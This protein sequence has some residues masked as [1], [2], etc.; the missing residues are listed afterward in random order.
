MPN[1]PPTQSMW[2]FPGHF[3]GVV[4]LAQSPSN[5]SHTAWR[6]AT[7]CSTVC[8]TCCMLSFVA[9]LWG[10]AICLST[11]N[12]YICMSLPSILAIMVKASSIQGWTRALRSASFCLVASTCSFSALAYCIFASNWVRTIVCIVPLTL[13]YCCYYVCASISR[14]YMLGSS[15]KDVRTLNA[16]SNILVQS[17]T[18]L[19]ISSNL[20]W[21]VLTH[22]SL[23]S[24]GVE[25]CAFSHI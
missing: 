8:W 16:S 11:Y 3:S 13:S 12:P 22:C 23:T 9:S 1:R 19:P 17:Y 24:R 4:I 18:D 15:C 14:C 5:W 20:V 7:H 25:G 10:S 6:S 2:L 21:I